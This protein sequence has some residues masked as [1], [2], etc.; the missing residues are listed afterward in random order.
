MNARIIGRLIDDID[1]KRIGD[2]AKWHK[3]LGKL[4]SALGKTEAECTLQP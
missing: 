1:K 2:V 4:E 3:L